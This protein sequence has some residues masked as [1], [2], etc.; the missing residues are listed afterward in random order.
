[1][2]VLDLISPKKVRMGYYCGASDISVYKKYK[3]LP[4]P[5]GKRR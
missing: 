5:N 2:Q 1:M 4:S 3:N